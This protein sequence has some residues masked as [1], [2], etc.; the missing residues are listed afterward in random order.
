MNPKQQQI[1][2]QEVKALDGL[3]Q[4][5]QTFEANTE[6]IENLSQAIKHLEEPFLLVVVGEFN[7]GKSSFLNALLG[8]KHLATGV[9]PTTSKINLL[10]Y[11]KS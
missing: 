8:G 1:L 6:D 5:L 11:I 9:T 10:R 3:R 7:A 4:T 2:K